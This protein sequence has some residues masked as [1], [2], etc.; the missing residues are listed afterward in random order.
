[1]DCQTALWGQIKQELIIKF[2][3]RCNDSINS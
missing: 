1:M 3:E 2:G